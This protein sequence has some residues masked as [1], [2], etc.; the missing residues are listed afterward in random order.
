M[1]TQLTALQTRSAHLAVEA[2]RLQGFV[3]SVIRETTNAAEATE[4]P[5]S[6]QPHPIP[7]LSTEEIQPQSQEVKEHP[8]DR[9]ARSHQAADHTR[10]LLTRSEEIFYHLRAWQ[11]YQAEQGARS[12]RLPA[13]LSS[14]ASSTP[15]LSHVGV[16]FLLIEEKPA[17][18]AL[19]QEALKEVP[20]PCR[21]SVLTH[22]SEIEAFVALTKSAPPPSPPQVILLDSFAQGMEAAEMVT[23]LGNLP[24]YDQIPMI[25][26]SALP[27][28]DGQRRSTSLGTT[29]FVQKPEKLQPLFDAVA[30]IVERWGQS[31]TSGGRPRRE[32]G[33]V[34]RPMRQTREYLN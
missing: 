13:A 1:V 31:A 7:I 15:S 20:I 28:M 9:I 5:A 29:A 26:F 34:G 2:S 8:R 14:P 23:L 11:E 19:F 24:G 16:H 4:E 10:Q 18:I 12:L 6:P 32:R 21:V 30:G 3:Q 17:H 25:L 33:R 22:P 27:E